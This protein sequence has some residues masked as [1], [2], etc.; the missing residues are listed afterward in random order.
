MDEKFNCVFL[1]IL[2]A[3]AMMTRENMSLDGHWWGYYPG[4]NPSFSWHWSSFEFENRV[5]VYEIYGYSTCKRVAA[6]WL[7][8]EY[9]ESSLIND[10]QDNTR[11]TFYWHGLTLI[12]AWISCHM[13]SKV[14][15]EISIPKHSISLGMD[16]WLHPTLYNGCNFLKMGYVLR[17]KL[18]HTG[19]HLPW[20]YT[21]QLAFLLDWI[22]FV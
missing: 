11:G 21:H 10:C 14:W 4:T 7:E 8:V 13:P 12:P 18:L 2:V 22:G 5:P 15:D 17:V 1:P 20:S 6:T 19:I 3:L 16:K 9:K